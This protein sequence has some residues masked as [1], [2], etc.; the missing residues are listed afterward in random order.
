MQPR[1]I[2]LFQQPDQIP[3]APPI[4][5]LLQPLRSRA[6]DKGSPSSCTALVASMKPNPA[7]HLQLQ[8]GLR[9]AT[10]NAVAVEPAHAP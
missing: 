2:T 5:H 6:P 9:V 3:V 4:H 1:A 8:T 10:E 7:R